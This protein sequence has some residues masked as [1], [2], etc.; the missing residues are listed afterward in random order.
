[1]LTTAPKCA[2][3]GLWED[4]S[5]LHHPFFFIYD[6]P[7]IWGLSLL[8]GEEALVMEPCCLRSEART[9]AA[10]WWKGNIP[11][12]C[13]ERPLSSRGSPAFPLMEINNN[14]QQN[15]FTLPSKGVRSLLSFSHTVHFP[16]LRSRTCMLLCIA[17]STVVHCGRCSCLC[18]FSYASRALHVHPIAQLQLTRPSCIL[19]DTCSAHL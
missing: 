6:K 7:G 4:K 12:G 8:T 17:F 10:T 9:R 18:R 11:Q 2:F 15:T 19:F 1:M 14:K 5:L 16:V 13:R 3:P